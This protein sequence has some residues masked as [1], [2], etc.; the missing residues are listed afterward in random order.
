MSPILESL[1]VTAVAG[2]VLLAICV[3][4][5]APLMLYAIYQRIGET[6]ALLRYLAESRR[7][8]PSQ[9][10]PIYKE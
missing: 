7:P 1:S 6:N 10:T 8:T 3:Y 2:L 4:L 5:L 9:S